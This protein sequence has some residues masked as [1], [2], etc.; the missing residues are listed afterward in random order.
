[1]NFAWVQHLLVIFLAIG[2]PLWD[3][4]EVPRLKAS[5]APRKKVKYYWRIVA[6]LWICAAIAIATIGFKPAFYLHPGP[7]EI[8]WLEHG[9]RGSMIALGMATGSF[10]A[11][12]VTAILALFS[13]RIREKSGK[14][15]KK[16]AFILPSSS[17]ERRWWWLLCITAGVCEELVYRGF[18][19]HYLHWNPIHLTLTQALIAASLIFGIGHLYQG[20]AGALST[21]IIGF[22]L[23]CLF[24]ITGNLLLPMILHAL[25]DLR[26]L[27][28][29]PEDFETAT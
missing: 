9:S 5:T 28:M 15:A 27:L 23:G 8:S 17:E 11:I 22:I 24:L 14:A 13:P 20:I 19:L 6:V 21:V 7:G 12:F 10:I 2:I 3:W 16:M 4:Y 26:V 18:L 25:M 1:M 29:L